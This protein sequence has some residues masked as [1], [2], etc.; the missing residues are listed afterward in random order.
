[1]KKGRRPRTEEQHKG[2]NYKYC[3][4]SAKTKN[5]KDKKFEPNK[6]KEEDSVQE[7][8]RRAG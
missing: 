2:M 6:R 1:M 7:Q 4:V 5:I 3:M 8:R